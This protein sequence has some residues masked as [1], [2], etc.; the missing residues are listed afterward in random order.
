MKKRLLKL[1]G[2]FILVILGLFIGMFIAYYFESLLR[3]IIQDIFKFS[4]SNKIRFVGKNFYIFS[5]KSFGLFI[6]LS[7]IVFVYENL[8]N[9][10]KTI[11]KNFFI[12]IL[13]F[14][15]S[16]FLISSIYANIKITECT[17]CKDGILSLHWNRI[18]YGFIIGSSAII[19]IIP[20][21]ARVIKRL[22]KTN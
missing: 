9:R 15:V 17:N 4:T 16:L 10:G 19:S 12:Y 7:I 11:L 8:T 22:N 21:I 13:F 5:N 18:N 20:T 1:T 2:W 3:N 6:G 14:G